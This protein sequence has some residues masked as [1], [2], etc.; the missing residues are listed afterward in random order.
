MKRAG[1]EEELGISHVLSFTAAH[2]NTGE[3]ICEAQN[4]YGAMN[5]TNLQIT[6]PGQSMLE[7]IEFNHCYT[8]FGRSLESEL[9]FNKFRSLNN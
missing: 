7:T 4:F 3:Y 9:F 8:S 1:V 2:G 5:S 6:V